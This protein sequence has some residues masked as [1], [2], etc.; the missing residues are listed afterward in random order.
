M[1]PLLTTS[2]EAYSKLAGYGMETYQKEEGG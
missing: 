1:S 2:D